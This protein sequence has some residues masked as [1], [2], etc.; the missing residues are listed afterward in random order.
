M[1]ICHCSNRG[2]DYHSAGDPGC[3]HAM[4]TTPP[5]TPKPQ[6]DPAVVAARASEESKR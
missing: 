4:T 3:A 2:D 1:T 6:T 5:P